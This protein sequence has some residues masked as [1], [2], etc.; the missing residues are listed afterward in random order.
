MLRA[1]LLLASTAFVGKGCSHPV[2]VIHGSTTL[3]RRIMEPYKAEIE[4]DLKT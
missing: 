1:M 4:A 3:F 2:L